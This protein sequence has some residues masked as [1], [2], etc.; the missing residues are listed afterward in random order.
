[1]VKKD[2]AKYK[3]EVTAMGNQS[4]ANYSM[5]SVKC[6]AGAL[7]RFLVLFVID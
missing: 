2:V 6:M 7:D 3:H 1:M 4:D 5:C